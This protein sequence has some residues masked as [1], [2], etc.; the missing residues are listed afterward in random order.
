MQKNLFI[1]FFIIGL[2]VVGGL[3]AG[4]MDGDGDLSENI[5]NPW[6]EVAKPTAYELEKET[7][8]TL[9]ELHT[10]DELER[11]AKIVIGNLICRT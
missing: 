11:E 2:I 4:L 3:V 8:E 5:S 1:L 7:Q 9:R 6:I 10:G